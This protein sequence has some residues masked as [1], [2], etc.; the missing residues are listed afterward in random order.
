MTLC[1]PGAKDETTSTEPTRHGHFD[2]TGDVLS[3]KMGSGASEIRIEEIRIRKDRLI[4]GKEKD[5]V[6]LKKVD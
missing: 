6:V 3:L 1:P 5:A 2:I 4:L